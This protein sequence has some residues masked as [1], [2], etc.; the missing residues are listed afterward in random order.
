MS[1]IG[2]EKIDIIE[3]SA[4]ASTFVASSLSPAKALSVT[5]N[6]TEHTATVEV[7]DDQ[8]SL[9]IGKGG[10]NVRLA[11]KLTGWRIDIKGV[12][13]ETVGSSDGE[14]VTADETV[15]VAG[16]TAA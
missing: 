5:L 8:L 9:A 6:D 11:A 3:W 1:E 10:Q 2:A 4:D 12:A 14:T 15:A 16:E 13:G 7:A